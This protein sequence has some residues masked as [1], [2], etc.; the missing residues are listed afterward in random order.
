MLYLCL[1]QGLMVIGMIPIVISA[2]QK[3]MDKEAMMEYASSSNTVKGLMVLESLLTIAV[4]LGRRY[5]KLSAGRIDR[6]KLWTMVGMAALIAF[7]WMF[8]EMS[9]LQL[10]EAD[11]LFPDEAEELERNSKMWTGL[12]AIVVGILV[13]ITE[14]IGFRGVLMGGLL[15]MRCRP[16]VA[17]VVSAIVFAF[18]HGTLLQLFGTTVFGIITGWL[19]WRTKSLLP[20]MIVH[21]V[22]N[23]TAVALVLAFPYEEPGKKLWLLFLAL[24][25]P[26]LLI[27]LNWFRCG[28]YLPSRA[29]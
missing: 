15:R 29:D 17:I 18:W 12:G 21:M 16:W 3:G 10:A 2:I 1:S 26:L 4:F 28:R 22:N 8:T 20:G 19:Y 13:P 23:S 6:S 11:N 9:I 5:V 25:L 14:E 7:G 27:G 24:C